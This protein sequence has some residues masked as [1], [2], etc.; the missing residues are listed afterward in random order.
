MSW[1]AAQMRR[2]R[3]ALTVVV[4]VAFLLQTVPYPAAA[5]TCTSFQSNLSQ[6]WPIVFE[7]SWYS[8]D[9]ASARPLAS[10]SVIEGDRIVLVGAFHNENLP[11]PVIRT[12]C[13]V[14]RGVLFEKT[15]DLVVPNSTYNPFSGPVNLTQFAWVLVPGIE[16]GDT[17]RVSVDFNN[18]DCDIMGWWAGTDNTTWTYGNNLLEDQMATGTKPEVGSFIAGQDGTLAIGVFDYDGSTGTFEVTVDT[19]AGIEYPPVSGT[20]VEF[21]TADYLDRNEKLDITFLGWVDSD[22]AYRADYYNV[23]IVNYFAPEVLDI[24]VSGEHPTITFQW[25]IHD[26]NAL[27][28]LTSDL[29]VSMDDGLTFQWLARDLCSTSYTWDASRWLNKDYHAR[30]VVRDSHGDVGSAD[31]YQ[32]VP[33][34]MIP[35]PSTTTSRPSTT[36]SATPPGIMTQLSIVFTLASSAVILTVLVLWARTPPRRMGT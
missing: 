36:S 16:E 29:L 30:I 5:L 6:G 18:G 23:T 13:D 12:E 21:S 7:G 25:T 32:Y 20:E 2:A 14:V 11:Q 1:G 8:A 24:V 33:T 28:T 9:N 22:N 10:S 27:D 26:R 31:W 19:R 3:F 15:G 17:V 4:A 34:D 35:Y